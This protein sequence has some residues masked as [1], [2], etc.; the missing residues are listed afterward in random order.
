MGISDLPTWNP[1]SDELEE[2]RKKQEK[3]KADRQAAQQLQASQPTASPTTPNTTASPPTSTPTNISQA[4]AGGQEEFNVRFEAGEEDTTEDT[5]V[6]DEDFLAAARNIYRFNHNGQGFDGSDQELADYALDTMGWFNYNL[7]KMTVDAAI[8]SRADDNTKASFLYLMDAYDDKNISWDGTWRFIKGVSTDPTTYAGLA[9]FGI[10]TAVSQGT[11][12]VGKEGLKALLKG[13][14]RNTVIAATEGAIY[15][16]VDDINRQVIETSVTGEEIDTFRT[17]KASGLSALTAGTIGLAATPAI[18]KAQQLLGAKPKK[19]KTTKGAAKTADDATPADE[20][21]KD[22]NEAG[23]KLVTRVQQEGA[24]EPKLGVTSAILKIREAVEKT[25]KDGFVAVDPETGVQKRKLIKDATDMLTTVL[26]KV[27]RNSDGSVDTNSL[28]QQILGMQLTQAEFNALGISVQRTMSDLVEEVEDVVRRQ[29][30]DM[31]E[32]AA[33]KLGAE[34]EELEDLF[35]KLN[36]LDE[37]FRS[38]AARSQGA[39]QKNIYRGELLN[40]LPEDIKVKENITQA[41]ADREWVALVDKQRDILSKDTDIKRLNGEIE[42]AIKANRIEKAAKLTAERRDLLKQKMD[43]Q[44]PGIGYKTRASFRRTVEGVNEFVIG[45]VFTTSTI[46]INTLPSLV[47]TIYKPFLNF[48]VE[49]DYASSGLRKMTGTYGAMWKMREGA[50]KAAIAAYKY[51]R[52]MLTGDYSRFIENHNVIPQRFKG[53]IPAGSVI[54][55]FPNILNMTDEFF[56]QLNYRGYV[57]GQAT[58]NAI[59]HNKSLKR[60]KKGKALKEYIQ[61]EVDKVI[62]NAY[63]AMDEV[64]I[65]QNLLEQ[66][67]ARGM[68]PQQAK[69]FV[70]KEFKKDKDR[71]AKGKESIFRNA[72]NKEGRSYTEDLL[73]KRQFTGDGFASQTAQKYEQFVRDNPWMKLVGQLFFR[74]PVRVFEE[75]IRMTPGVQ[76]IAPKYISDLRGANGTA[77]QVRAQGEALLSYGIAGYVMMQYAQ[78][79][80]TGAGTGD[81]KRRKMQEDTDRQQPYTIQFDDGSTF[82]FRNYDPFSTPIKIMVNAFERYEEVEYRR[83]QGE[84]V[85]D[86]MAL[87]R[88]RL[89]VGVG[90]LFN[91]I[92]DA[93]LMEGL[94]QASELMQSFGKED[95][96]YKDILKFMGQKSQLAFPNMI[97]KTKNAFFDDAPTLKNPIGFL[98]HLEARMDLGFTPVSN[99]YDILGNARPIE[100]PTNSLHGVFIT[101]EE[102]R[103][104][105]KS[106]RDLFV[107]RKMELIAIATDSAFEIP[108]RVPNFFG[109]RDLRTEAYPGEDKTL[110]DRYVEIYREANG[111]ITNILYPI[112]SNGDRMYGTASQDGAISQVVRSVIA[113]QRQVAAILLL[114]ELGKMPEFTNRKVRQGEAKAGLRDDTIFPNVRN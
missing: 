14:M 67:E 103:R 68:N 30:R 52:G 110:Y 100:A 76:F 83:R 13:G 95:A 2:I 114:E 25:T 20:V 41:E 90:S 21:T 101:D 66:A 57:E 47:K 6:E 49:G 81:Y 72:K 23:E 33:V 60:P 73:F 108:A 39:R 5:L 96:W 98:Q 3:I 71:Q 10:G 18:N 50:A 58:A 1:S 106:E 61:K 92:K 59:L 85:E 55:F 28:N 54:R 43:A 111:G 56:Q 42:R 46:V 84:Y 32:D 12:Q 8:I 94:D 27:T 7:P 80:I 89:Y 53:R 24:S 112:L 36:T 63:E 40:L 35:R 104:K 105:G 91:A 16:A 79:N 51:E 62:L 15:G 78:G 38:T 77:R 87:I 45:T 64:Q 29:Q 93:N 48:V 17:L 70:A 99:Q 11:K 65:K 31:S 82:S 88:E 9:T 34:R 26:G 86:E 44:N 19:R 113:K 75:G 74:T 4:I 107:L 22:I 109:N 69:K 102:D 37:G 97:Y